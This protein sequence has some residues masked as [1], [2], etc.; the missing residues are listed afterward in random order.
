MKGEL[1]V[2]LYEGKAAEKVLALADSG[3]GYII[4]NKS[5]KGLSLSVAAVF[6][7]PLAPPRPEN[8]EPVTDPEKIDKYNRIFDQ[9]NNIRLTKSQKSIDAANLARK[10]IESI[11]LKKSH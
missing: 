9:R 10:R 3:V 8:L 7:R 5:G 2:G 4:L 6:K 11:F 1:V